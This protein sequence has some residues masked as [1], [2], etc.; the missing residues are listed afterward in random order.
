MPHLQ[1]FYVIHK[2][3]GFYFIIT[4]IYFG[5]VCTMVFLGKSEDN[6]MGSV[7]SYGVSP[8]NQI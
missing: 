7:L 5:G 2:H 3:C 4:F 1:V 6:F 8:G